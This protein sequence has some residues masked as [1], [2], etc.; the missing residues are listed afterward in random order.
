MIKIN[1]VEDGELES[2]AANSDSPSI[3]LCTKITQIKVMKHFKCVLH[4]LIDHRETFY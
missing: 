1:N 2:K 3:F 4:K